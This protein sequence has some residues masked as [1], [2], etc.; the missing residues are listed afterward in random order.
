MNT[1]KIAHCY[2]CEKDIPYSEVKRHRYYC[3]A[4]QKVWM[5]EKTI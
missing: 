4:G 1:H 5:R 3:T 2:F